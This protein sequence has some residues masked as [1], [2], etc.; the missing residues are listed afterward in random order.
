M[1][2]LSWFVDTCEM[3]KSRELEFI[4]FDL[5]RGDSQCVGLI[6]D[7]PGFR[8]RDC[9]EILVSMGVLDVIDDLDHTKQQYFPA[10]VYQEKILKLKAEYREYCER[11]LH[12]WS[13]VRLDEREH[14]NVWGFRVLG[15]WKNIAN[16]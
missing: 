14:L 13:F 12:A 2:E 9:G 8:C 4:F 3:C 10:E 1:S 15:D 7:T 16:L 6:R 5:K 11:Q